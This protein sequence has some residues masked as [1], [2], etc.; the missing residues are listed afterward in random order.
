MAQQLDQK[1]VIPGFDMKSSDM[2]SSDMKSSDMKS[3]DI[4]V[5]GGGIAGAAM[6][7]ALVNQNE[8]ELK[9]ALV[10]AGVLQAASPKTDDTSFDSRVCALTEASK[11]LLDNLGAW[12]LITAERASPYQGMHVWDANGTGAISFSAGELGVDSLGYIVENSVIRNA[13]FKR[14]SDSSVHM[15]A[16][17]SVRSIAIETGEQAS[18]RGVTVH[19][20]GEQQIT[21]R[22]LIGADGANSRV[23]RWAG[24][25]LRA[26]DYLHHGIV[27]TVELEKPHQNTAWQNFLNTGP[28]AFLPLPDSADGRHFCSIVWSL[29]PDE[30]SRVMELDDQIFMSELG[31]AIEHRFGKVLGADQRHCFPLRQRHAKQYHRGPVAV[32][33]DAAHTIHPLAG[34]GANLGLL[35]VA[36][37][38]EI[39]HR[40]HSR[41]DDFS[42]D[43]ALARYQRSREGHNLAMAG[44]M[45][46]LQHMFMSDNIWMRWLRNAG[47]NMT[48]ALPVLKQEIVGRAMGIRGDLPKLAQPPQL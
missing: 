11:N 47:L 43:Q 28:L 26:W 23:R 2:K 34:Q 21:S 36:S 6:A 7:L 16:N 19:L 4:I 24:I 42:S 17:T 27:T 3:F 20:E 13:L 44:V 40:A 12:E 32:I 31:T 14:L 8:S 29:V 30:S 35:D 25:P 37:L 48:D 22:L 46:G 38:T 39:L 45:E 15:L 10:D 33:G 5:L 1:A 18:E 9:V 41:G